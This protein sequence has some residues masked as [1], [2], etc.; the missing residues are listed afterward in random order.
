MSSAFESSVG[1]GQYVHLAAAI[2]AVHSVASGTAPSATHTKAPDTAHGA[3]CSK[4]SDV[5]HGLATAQ[6]FAADV[7]TEPLSPVALQAPNVST[8]L[9]SRSFHAWVLHSAA[10]RFGG[11]ERC[12]AEV[13]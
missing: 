2:S 3:A 11:Y 4:A 8:F 13:H 12:T 6:W 10:V 5:A 1:L 9:F 7:V